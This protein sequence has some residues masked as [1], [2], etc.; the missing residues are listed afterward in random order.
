MLDPGLASFFLA[1]A[2]AGVLAIPGLR[3]AARRAEQRA[4]ETCGRL[5]ILGEQTC[6]CD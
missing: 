3:K 1:F 5:K 4:C 6:D 2:F